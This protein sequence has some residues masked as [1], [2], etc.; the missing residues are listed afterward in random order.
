MVLIT[1]LFRNDNDGKYITMSNP[2]EV[3]IEA[4]SIEQLKALIKSAEDAIELKKA[5]EIQA[6]REQMVQMANQVDMTP[7]GILA[8][9]TRKKRS[10]GKAKFRNLN[11]PW[12]TWTGHGK[13]PGWMKQA[14]ENGADIE[15]FRIPE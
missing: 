14:L 15:A 7:E 1:E 11:S 4:S 10:S 13:K 9:S 3:I 12:Q 2:L 6:I 8:Y 5:G